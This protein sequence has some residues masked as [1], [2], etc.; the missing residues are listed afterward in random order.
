[1]NM[2]KGK[3]EP[4]YSTH[5]SV[6]TTSEFVSIGMV[7]SAIH[8]YS[9][10]KIGSRRQLPI[11]LSYALT[12]H[13]VQSLTLEAVAMDFGKRM[14]RWAPHGSV[15]T[16]LSRCEGIETLWVKGLSAAHI[17]ISPRAKK[18]MEKGEC[19][20]KKYPS[21]VICCLQDQHFKPTSTSRFAR[22]RP[23][24]KYR[25]VDGSSHI[26]T[27]YFPKRALRDVSNTINVTLIH[28]S[29]GKKKPR[30]ATE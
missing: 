27:N 11:T 25:A 13:G 3:E 9:G 22:M 15:Y 17:S 12:V 7:E 23:R 16:A 28:E 20:R 24:N 14:S 2:I 26:Q 29:P 18:L 8:D 10:N 6:A 4:V 21:R 19:I 5:C 30:I 1:M